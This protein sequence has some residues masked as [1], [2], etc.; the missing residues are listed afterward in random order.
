[1]QELQW[2]DD[3]MRWH[4]QFILSELALLAKYF[5]LILAVTLPLGWLLGLQ[6]AVLLPWIF[7]ILIGIPL[8]AYAYWDFFE[9]SLQGDQL[10][11]T[12]R[13]IKTFKPDQV[14]VI[15]LNEAIIRRRQGFDAF[16]MLT[17]TVKQNGYHVYVE[18]NSEAKQR[19][20]ELLE[21]PR[22]QLQE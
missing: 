15:K 18:N 6:Y 2:K 17:L 3:G 14:T 19:L 10:S 1:M 4:K 21:T 5:L 7:L 16:T 22:L 11:I 13:N 9:F 8:V 20:M 12:H